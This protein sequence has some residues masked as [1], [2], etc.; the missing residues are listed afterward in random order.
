MPEPDSGDGASWKELYE[1]LEGAAPSWP[2]T[3]VDSKDQPILNLFFI[4]RA[5]KSS[6]HF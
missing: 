3:G 6:L 2:T 1:K 5:C 4:T